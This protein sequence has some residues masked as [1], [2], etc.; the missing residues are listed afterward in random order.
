LEQIDIMLLQSIQTQ[1]D[2]QKLSK[3]HKEKV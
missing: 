3:N 1:Q 2:L